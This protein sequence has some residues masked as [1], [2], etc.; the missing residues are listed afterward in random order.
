MKKNMKNLERKSFERFI[1]NKINL[2]N[3]IK[4]KGGD[5]GSNPPPEPPIQP[6]PIK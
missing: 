4:I 1:I 6:P 5:G 3:S 2:E